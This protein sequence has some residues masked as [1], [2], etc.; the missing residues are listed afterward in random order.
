MLL[1]KATKGAVHMGE[2]IDFYKWKQARL[3][4]RVPIPSPRLPRR[5]GKEANPRAGILTTQLL[6]S[7]RDLE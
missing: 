3:G 2:V 5:G 1:L 6:N 4:T 7:L